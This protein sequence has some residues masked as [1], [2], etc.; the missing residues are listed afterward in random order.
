MLS[1]M[2]ISCHRN[3]SFLPS[4]FFPIKFR[5]IKNGSSFERCLAL[6]SIQFVA[7]SPSTDLPKLSPNTSPPL[8]PS[9]CS[10]ISAG[11]PHFST[12]YMRTWVRR[13]HSTVTGYCNLTWTFILQGSGY[14]YCIAWPFDFDW[15]I[16]RSQI[17]H[18]GIRIL[19]TS[20]LDSE[21]IRQWHNTQI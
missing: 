21:F 13:F 6:G 7:V 2:Q 9:R 15:K 4:S 17:S 12:G 8:P 18:I 3:R 10:T 1:V 20:R 16:W 11:L 14:V 5:F 19:L